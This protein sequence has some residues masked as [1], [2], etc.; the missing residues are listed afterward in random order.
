MTGGFFYWLKYLPFAVPLFDS[1]GLNPGG[2]SFPLES[3]S[4]TQHHAGSQGM[5]E[6]GH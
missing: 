2:G 5:R 3:N 4:G 6:L 1:V